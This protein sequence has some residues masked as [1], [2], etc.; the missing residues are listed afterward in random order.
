MKTEIEKT[1]PLSEKLSATISIRRGGQLEPA[2][3]DAIFVILRISLP[4]ENSETLLK[5]DD[6]NLHPDLIFA[7]RCAP[8]L[9]S[10]LYSD[11]GTLSSDRLSRYK[12]LQIHHFRWDDAISLAEETAQSALRHLLQALRA[13]EAALDRA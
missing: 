13:R 11:W 4:C 2:V 6:L 5:T 8:I 1:F 3:S 9:K 10:E 7:T 12:E